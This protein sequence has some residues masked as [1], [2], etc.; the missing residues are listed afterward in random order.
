MRRYRVI[1]LFLM[2]GT[3][4]SAGGQ[5]LEERVK[6]LEAELAALQKQLALAQAA[7]DDARLTELE[8][9]LSV[10]AEELER[11]RLGELGEAVAKPKALDLA[12]A[13]AKVYGA[14]PGVSVGGYGELLYQNFAS[15]RD[16]GRPSGKVD[17]PDAYRA[18]LYAVY[19]FDDG[20]IFNS[21]LEV[22]HAHTGK[23]GEVE[24]ESAYL[25]WLASPA[26]NLRA[27]LVLVPLGLVNEIDEPTT[28]LPARRSET[29]TRILPTTWLELGVGAFGDLGPLSYRTYVLTAL[30]ATKFS[31]AGLRDG[32]QSGAKAKAE[33]W[34]WVGRVDWTATP[35]FLAG[36][37]AYFGEAGQNLTA[38]SGNKLDVPVRIVEGH[39]EWKPH[40]WTVRGVVAQADVDQAGDLNRRLGLGGSAGVARRLEGGYVEVAY[41]LLP[42]EKK[43]LAPFFRYEAINTQKAM[44]RGF[45]AN[46]ANDQ[47]VL[48]LG[49]AFQPLPQIIFK[50]D[51]QNYRNDAGTGVNQWNL[52]LG[53]VF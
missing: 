52:A 25:D 13:A 22:E 34:A 20:W 21:E 41:D 49:I 47:K 24:L 48:T 37:G 32:R 29:E 50:A 9:N 35:G 51:V 38:V 18:V 17:T 19:K 15:R 23:G 11:L 8:R 43:T 14:K 16:D 53:Y 44:P 28:F 3:A 7:D 33:S 39:V 12:P 42:A 46:P 31:A 2:L 30:D 1:I 45:V 27:G 4:L 5:T 10:L 36:I 6:A 40:R 26:A